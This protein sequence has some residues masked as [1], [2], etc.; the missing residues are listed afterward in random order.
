MIAA[1]IILGLMGAIALLIWLGVTIIVF[2]H[3]YKVFQKRDDDLDYAVIDYST[4][5]RLYQ[6]N[7]D[8]YQLSDFG[9]LYR[10][11]INHGWTTREVRIIFKTIFDYIKFDVDRKHNKKTSHIIKRRKQEEQGLSKLRNLAQQDI[12]NLRAKLDAEFEQEKKK[13]QEIAANMRRPLGELSLLTDSNG[14][15]KCYQDKP[16]YIDEL[17]YYFTKDGKPILMPWE[18]K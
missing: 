6:V 4:L 7:P 13:T 15:L 2:I 12:D 1:L 9:Q 11:N 18:E 14:R 17:G 16:I 3:D 5:K 10:L 8:G